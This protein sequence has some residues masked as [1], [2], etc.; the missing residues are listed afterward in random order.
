MLQ[1]LSCPPAT[2]VKLELG[3]HEADSG[4]E[5]V[6]ELIRQTLGVAEWKARAE[7]EDDVLKG[8]E[9]GEG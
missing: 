1:Y 6:A 7:L 5:A 8:R 9:K 4:D 3:A 2:A